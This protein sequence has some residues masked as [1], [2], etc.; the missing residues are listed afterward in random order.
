M[1]MLRRVAWPAALILL[2]LL[3]LAARAETPAGTKVLRDVAYGPAKLQSMDVY[4]PPEPKA[5]PVI[6]MVHGGAWRIG[7]K[8]HPPVFENKVARWVPRGFIFISVNYPM[9]P[10]SDPVEQADDI[11][12]A[13]AAAQ[14]AAAGWGG[15][16]TRFIL[17]GH[18][19]GAHLVTLLNAD[20]SRATKLGAKPW[21][22]TISLDSGALDVPAIMNHW[23]PKLYDQAFGDDPALWE[24]SSPIHHLTKDSPPWLGVCSSPRRTSCGTN[25]IYAAKARDLGTRAETLGQELNHGEIDSELGKPNAYTDAVETFMTSLDPAVKALLKR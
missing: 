3:A 21:L 13:I 12:R 15:D 20:P 18:S 23:H 14:K 24:A 2:T 4:L 5:A 1:T 11:A 8:R 17:M 22:G 9:A 16:P 6:L 10:E 7:D 25:R 19:A